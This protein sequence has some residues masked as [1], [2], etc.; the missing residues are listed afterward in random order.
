MENPWADGRSREKH[1]G[2][3]VEVGRVSR[4]VRE[5]ERERWQGMRNHSDVAGIEG[6][7]ANKGEFEREKSDN[8]YFQEITKGQPLIRFFFFFFFLLP[9]KASYLK[10]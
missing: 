1:D 8:F 5:R 3:K 6:G 2:W 7:V 10:V 4:N 9:I